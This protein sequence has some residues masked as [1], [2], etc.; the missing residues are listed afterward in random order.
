MS[1]KAHIC[2]GNFFAEGGLYV[3]VIRIIYGRVFVVKVLQAVAR[4]LN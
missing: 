4:A 3:R 1:E 2:N